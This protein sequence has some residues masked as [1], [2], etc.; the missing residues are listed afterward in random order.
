MIILSPIASALPTHTT[1]QG[2][3]ST[4][5]TSGGNWGNGIPDAPSDPIPA[6]WGIAFD[7]QPFV[8]ASL[9]T[10]EMLVVQD[11][12]KDVVITI[13]GSR[14]LALQSWQEGGEDIGIY[15]ST[16]QDNLT[17]DGGGTLLQTDDKASGANKSVKWNVTDSGDLTISAGALELDPAMELV[18]N[19]G[20][21]RTVTLTSP[22][23]ST[24]AAV[25]KTGDGLLIFGGSNLFSG[26]LAVNGGILSLSAGNQVNTAPGSLVVDSVTLDGGTI[27]VTGTPPVRDLS[28]PTRFSLR[29]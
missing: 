5:W 14:T 18:I 15:M 1:W 8:N 3:V 20:T 28:P 19:S 2:D 16:A 9:I 22:I 17:I 27:V 25:T 6:N 7:N 21:G 24:T 13:N 11:P 4:N 12:N 10:A 29:P 26:N 23:S